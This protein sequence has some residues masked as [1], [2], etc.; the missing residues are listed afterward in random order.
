MFFFF[1]QCYW[2]LSNFTSARVRKWLDIRE[3]LMNLIKMLNRGTVTLNELNNSLKLIKLQ[4]MIKKLQC[5]SRLWVVVNTKNLGTLL[6]QKHFLIYQIKTSMKLCHNGTILKVRY[7]NR[8]LTLP[9]PHPFPK[10][11]VNHRIYNS[12]TVAGS[13]M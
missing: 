5:L 3:E 7:Y 4:R 10:G 1:I 2:S 12:V 9:V 8:A 6:H 11:G 13:K